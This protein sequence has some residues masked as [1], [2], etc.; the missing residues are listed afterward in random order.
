MLSYTIDSKKGDYYGYIFLNSTLPKV[1]VNFALAHEI[2]HVFYQQKPI[3]Q[4]VECNMRRH[5]SD[6]RDELCANLFAGMLLMPT[7]PFVSMFQKFKM[8][9]AKDTDTKLI[10]FSVLSCVGIGLVLIV[11]KSGRIHQQNSLVLDFC[12]EISDF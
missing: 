3:R 12:G 8:E 11:L 2:Y 9:E 4:K 7:K 10:A 1:N 5:Y 6:D